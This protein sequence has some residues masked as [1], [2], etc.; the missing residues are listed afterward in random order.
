MKQ[1][2][3]F[4]N[5][6]VLLTSQS[7]KAPFTSVFEDDGEKGYFHAVSNMAEG[8]PQ[9]ETVI[10]IYKVDDSLKGQ[11]VTI[12]WSDNGEQSA[13]LID[14]TFKAV[15]DFPNQQVFT[16]ENTPYDDIS[17]KNVKLEWSEKLASQFPKTVSDTNRRKL[18]QAVIESVDQ[19][20]E[21][22]RLSLFRSMIRSTLIIPYTEINDGKDYRYLVFPYEKEG[23][24]LCTFTDHEAFDQTLGPDFPRKTV[25]V[26]SLFSLVQKYN[27]SSVLVTTTENK[28]IRIQPEEFPLF[29]LMDDVQDQDIGS[30][31][32]TM[33]KLFI[34]IPEI[35]EYKEW[36]DSLKKALQQSE[37]IEKAYLFR[38]ATSDATFILG[39]DVKEKEDKQ[40]VRLYRDIVAATQ[41]TK[42]HPEPFELTVLNHGETLTRVVQTMVEPFYIRK[43]A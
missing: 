7:P 26:P 14:D 20:N 25:F 4:P 41:Q 13:L 15:I 35:T 28:S 33:G 23:D 21:S 31:L 30:L 36:V 1:T 18:K 3:V 29:A 22:S 16:Q 19:N 12:V 8:E 27:V 43:G 11:L 32:D 5:K 2:T 40:L 17:W 34:S 37:N 42:S 38:S 39:L 24:Y 10:P 6:P 9:V